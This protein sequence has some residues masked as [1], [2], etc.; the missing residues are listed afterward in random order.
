MIL[1]TSLYVPLI[2]VLKSGIYWNL[3]YDFAFFSSSHYTFL[4]NLLISTEGATQATS[5]NKSAE[6]CKQM[7]T[8]YTAHNFIFNIKY[9][10]SCII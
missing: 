4:E 10:Y 3:C 5:Y 6:K 1:K 8:F 9:W 7:K 2:T